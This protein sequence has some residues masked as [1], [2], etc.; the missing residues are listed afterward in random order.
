MDEEQSVPRRRERDEEFRRGLYRDADFAWILTSDLLAGLL[1]WGGI[2]WLADRWLETAPWLLVTG[3]VVG[4]ALGM[5][6]AI[7]R[8]DARS[9]AEEAERER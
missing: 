2:G 4:F 5:Y 1:A 7:R 9:R 8:A 3:I 6:L